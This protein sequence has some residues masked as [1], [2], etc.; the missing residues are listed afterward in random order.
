MCK[1]CVD[2]VRAIFP[3]VPDAEMG[4]FLLCTTCYPAGDHN[5]VRKQL[6]QNRAKMKTDDYHEC[7]AIADAEMDE[8]WRKSKAA[9]ADSDDTAT[10]PH[11]AENLN[12]PNTFWSD[13]VLRVDPQQ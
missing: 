3:Q 6:V 9:P 10:P 11:A 1:Q 7:Y 5:D 2:A 12:Q 8:A 4:D 13:H